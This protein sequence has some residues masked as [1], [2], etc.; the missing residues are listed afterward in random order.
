VKQN[1]NPSPSVAAPL[2]PRPSAPPPASAAVSPAR[3]LAERKA[4][5]AEI[6]QRNTTAN[7][8][9]LSGFSTEDLRDYLEHLRHARHKEVRLAGWVQRR[10]MRL[11]AARRDVSATAA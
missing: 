6:H 3:Q 8:N 2:R 7:A 11:A 4:I 1:L 10:L 5:I 9:F